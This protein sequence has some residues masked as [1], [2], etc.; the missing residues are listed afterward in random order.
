MKRWIAILLAALTLLTVTTGFAAAEYHTIGELRNAA[1]TRW[2]QTYET[3]WRTVEIDTEILL[4]AVDAIPVLQIGYR[5]PEAIPTSTENTWDK[6][7][8]HGGSLILYNFGQDVPR[9]ASG[10]RVNQNAEAVESWYGG[11]APENT[12]VPLS[13]I[14]FGEITALIDTELTRM[15]YDAGSFEIENPTRLW[16]QHWY[17]NGCKEDAL[18]GHILLNSEK[19]L[20][21]LPLFTH[22]LSAVSDHYNGEART[23]EYSEMGFGIA[24]GY[25]GYDGALSHLFVADAVVKAVL[26]SDVPLC[27]IQAVKETIE[28]EINAGHIRKIYD[29]ELGYVLYNE[30]GMYREDR[31]GIPYETIRYYAKPVWQVNCLYVRTAAGAERALPDDVFDERNSLDYSQL[32]VDAQTGELILESDAQDR[33]EYK[34]FLSWEDVRQ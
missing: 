33:C 18:A 1:Q 19:R 4:P 23:D 9:S 26:A 29:I 31:A 15:G 25:D 2:T 11:F 28:S 30:P 34:G 12:Y 13:D 20:Q 6:V 32:L 10:R 7:E 24:A 5:L 8:A 16:A 17:Y 22:I 3:K 14:T 27:S 21:G